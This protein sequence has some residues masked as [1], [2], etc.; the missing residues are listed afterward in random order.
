[1]ANDGAFH[2][3]M[4]FDRRWADDP[5]LGDH[6]GR[7]VWALGCATASAAPDLKM[8]AAEDFRTAAARRTHHPRS[9]AYAALGAAEVAAI[10]PGHQIARELLEDAIV[11]IDPTPESSR[12]V[13][14]WPWPQERLGYA[15]ARLPEALLAAGAALGREAVVERALGLLDWLLD[16]ETRDGHLSPTP[17]GGWGPGEPRPGFDQQPIEAWALA[18]ACARALALTNDDRWHDGVRL[19]AGWFLGENDLDAPLLQ[20]ESGG[21][22]DGLTAHGPN[23]N[24]GAESTLALIATSQHA[25]RLL[26]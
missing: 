5:E 26:A 10:E 22:S 18:D 11:T 1:M 17:V 3:R 6:W 19:A 4:G 16:V 14:D 25:Q 12:T 21:C 15:N 7:A 13:T 23:V 9:M 8:P 20:P 24:Q 2:N